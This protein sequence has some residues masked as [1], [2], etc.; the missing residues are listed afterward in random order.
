MT[1]II[2]VG[3]PRAGHA[4]DGNGNELLVNGVQA[5]YD[6]EN[7]LVQLGT[8]DYT[9]YSYDADGNRLSVSTRQ[10]APGTAPTG[11]V[12]GTTTTYLVDPTATYARVVLESSGGY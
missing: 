10:W 1:V 4:Y 3:Q 9:A 8:R 5:S 12:S 7:H 11:A 2:L 6:F